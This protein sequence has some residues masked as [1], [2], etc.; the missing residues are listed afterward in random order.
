MADTHDAEHDDQ[1]ARKQAEHTV[2]SATAEG[3]ALGLGLGLGQETLPAYPSSLLGDARLSGRGNGPV[4]SALV[5]RMQQSYGNRATQRFLQR[6]AAPRVQREDAP[7]ATDDEEK[8]KLEEETTVQTTRAGSSAVVPVQREDPP[9]GTAPAPATPSTNGATPA[10]ATPAPAATGNPIVA[11][12]WNASVVT[13]V[14]Q[15]A[16][17]IQGANPGKSKVQASINK[18]ESAREVTRQVRTSLPPDSAASLR[19]P[20]FHNAL[21]SFKKALE[22]HAGTVT[23]I[24]ETQAHITGID[25]PLTELGGQIANTPPAGASGGA[26]PPAPS[27]TP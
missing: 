17:D 11:A 7:E 20:G 21:T 23:P 3:Q 19:I 26:P 1:Q 10:P 5:Q 13:P 27:G 8:K 18:L 4:R 16:Q 12:M 2:Q 24:P 6:S 15:A 25:G 9:G 14:Q 22:P